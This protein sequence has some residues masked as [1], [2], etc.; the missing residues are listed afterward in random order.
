[1]LRYRRLVWLLALAFL[2]L[3]LLMAPI[4]SAGW[5]PPVNISEGGAAN[6]QVALDSEGN[7]T[8]VWE[9]WDGVHG[10]VESAFRP[11]GEPWGHPEVLSGAQGGE[12]PKVGVD[13][14]G[15]VTVVW[16][17]Y[18]WP[19]MF[20]Q[21][22]E[23]APGGNWTTPVDIAELPQAADSEPR[24]AVDWEGNATVVW[25]QGG[26]IMSSWRPFAGGWSKPAS[27]SPPNSYTP[28]VAMDARGDATVVWMH[29][30]SA[31]LVVESAY[32]PEQ[33]GW[34]TASLV[35]VPGEEGGD[36]FVAIDAR[37][38]L[39]AAWRGAYEGE[40][41]VRAAYRP[42]GGSWNEP[43]NASAAG[44]EVEPNS[45][46]TALDPEGDAMVAWSGYHTEVGGWSVVRAAYKAAGGAWEAPV[47][48]SA[49]GG[50]GFPSDV[51]FDQSGNAALIWQWA[52]SSRNL[53][54][55]SYRSA[56]GE[57]E[58][59]VNLSG[60]SGQAVDPVVVLDAPGDAT[61][62][63]GDA[64]AIWD[65]GSVVEAAGYDP[66]GAPDVEV[67]APEEAEV[68]E[69]VEFEIPSEGLYSPELEF[70]DGG[71]AAGSTAVHTYTASGEY[72]VTAAAAEELGYRASA[73]REINIVPS[74]SLARSEGE[75]SPPPQGET[76]PLLE[77]E[78]RGTTK[79][80]SLASRRE[81][82]AA[83]AAHARTLHR[84]RLVQA[85]LKR[86]GG[87]G[88]RLSH[89]A[90]RL[91]SALRHARHLAYA[92]CTVQY[93]PTLRD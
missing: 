10:V 27:L 34:E 90:H 47:S 6:P 35:S 23:R 46:R 58:A 13:R 80:P 85:Q 16:E 49:A 1:M 82:E 37:G 38:D 7:A 2:L 18:G 11:A 91:L 62:A 8:A 52:D 60:E 26:V 5:L 25:V 81:C 63:D 92:T 14:N 28:Q 30:S 32:R 73:V 31:Q 3:G 44:E 40:G 59:A 39:L 78:E 74:G 42:A 24:L 87:E 65:K 54:Q 15:N 41:F 77:V 89:R 93:R 22:V 9:R 69:P 20:V 67:E 61:A 19:T 70:G 83:R 36:P 79:Q 66:G 75:E 17:I 43:V 64:T 72:Q 76:S 55:A 29:D 51:V 33:G 12:S 53:I 86:G 48:L 84:F 71:K 45:V 21:A 57:W 68:G 50:N 56:G 4:A 88:G